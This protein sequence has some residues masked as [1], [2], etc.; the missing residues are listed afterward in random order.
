M[1]TGAT[2]KTPTKT[3]APP[4]P[5]EHSPET[6]ALAALTEQLE[7]LTVQ[8][9]DQTAS[10]RAQH[11]GKHRAARGASTEQQARELKGLLAQIKRVESATGAPIADALTYLERVATDIGAPPTLTSTQREALAAVGAQLRP[12]SPL[13]RPSVRTAMN[14]RQ[15]LSDALSTREAA[16]LLRLKDPSR[17]RQRIAA[18]TLLAVDQP[19]GKRLPRFQFTDSGELPGWAVV[20]PRVPAGR[21]LV[22]VQ[23]FMT[24]PHPDLVSTDGEA[25]S[26]YDWLAAG[27]DPAAVAALAG[28]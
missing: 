6:E 2:T 18:R 7:Q 24:T 15:L 28:E 26:P 23:R 13:D 20:A 1:S 3:T 16:D 22:A 12:M 4:A 10:A 5:N 9:T 8:Q 27:E 21:N 11:S 19:K 17:I 14:Y 25:V